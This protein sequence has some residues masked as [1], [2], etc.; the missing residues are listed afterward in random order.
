[1]LFAAAEVSSPAANAVA[2][3]DARLR[4][5]P[6]GEWIRKLDRA[7][8]PLIRLHDVRHTYATLSLDAGVERFVQTS[9]MAAVAYV[10]RPEITVTEGGHVAI[11]K[12]FPPV[13][14][15]TTGFLRHALYGDAA[16]RGRLKR[17]ATRGGLGTVC[18][19]LA[20]TADVRKRD[21]A[22]VATNLFITHEG[23]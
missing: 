20:Q 17:D 13:I 22:R 21:V 5:I 16:A 9:S 15:T 18:N 3:I 6:A 11:T 8:V 4:S 14:A 12:E 10:R 1:M 2:A 23:S 19:E 7:G